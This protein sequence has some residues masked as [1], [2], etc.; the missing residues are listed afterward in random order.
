MNHERIATVRNPITIPRES[1]IVLAL[2]ELSPG[3]FVLGEGIEGFP[4]NGQ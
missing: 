2:E 4:P 1:P 3:E